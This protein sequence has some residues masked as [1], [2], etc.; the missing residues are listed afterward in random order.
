MNFR[1]QGKRIQ[2]S[3][4]ETRR[5]LAQ[6]AA[7]WIYRDVKN[8]PRIPAPKLTEAVIKEYLEYAQLR[9]ARSSWQRDESILKLHF[10]PKFKNRPIHKI[11]ALD[12]DDYVSD[13]LKSV[14]ESTVN[15]EMDTIRAMF[16][17][18]MKWKYLESNPASEL[19]HLRVKNKKPPRFFTMSQCARLLESAP[20]SWRLTFLAAIL[21]GM[22]KRELENWRW[23]WID[24]E[25]NKIIVQAGGDFDTKNYQPREIEIH[26]KLRSELE[27]ISHT[28]E[29]VLVT[30][31]GSPR[32]NNFRRELIAAC[33]R[34]RL[35]E[36]SPHDLRHSFGSNLLMAGADVKSVQ[37]LMGHRDIRTTLRIYA[38]VTAHHRGAAIKKLTLPAAESPDDNQKN[39][40]NPVTKVRPQP[41]SKNQPIK[42]P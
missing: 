8:Y 11:A 14:S 33:R 36:I 4:G 5:D 26:P 21:T 9:K 16:A 17:C 1:C 40:V 6:L 31:N 30:E 20:P 39:G 38:H 12:L 7:E 34:A 42:K 3:T 24:F 28:G 15:R 2:R 41:F 27:A 29:F 18:A 32:K 13:R 19:K 37:E 35:P 10:Q 22:R 25:S 23:D